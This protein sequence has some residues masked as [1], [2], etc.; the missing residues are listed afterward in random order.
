MFSPSV[1]V[2]ANVLSVTGK[3]FFNGV[4]ADVAVTHEIFIRYRDD[5][6]ID[7]VEFEGKYFNILAAEDFEEHHE[8]LRLICEERGDKTLESTHA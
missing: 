6:D 2:W 3:T 7:F 5:L 8:F 1:N 4:N